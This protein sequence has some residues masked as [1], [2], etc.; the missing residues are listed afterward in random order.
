MT[1]V[2]VATNTYPDVWSN[3]EVWFALT[4]S[5]RYLNQRVECE[6]EIYSTEVTLHFTQN[7]ESER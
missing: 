1:S 5:R 7:S 6:L 3:Q 2:Q 4:V